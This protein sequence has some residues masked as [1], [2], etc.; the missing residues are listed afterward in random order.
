MLVLLTLIINLIPSLNNFLN[1]T[2]IFVQFPKIISLLGDVTPA[3][4][5]RIINIFSHPGTIILISALI[6]FWILNKS[7]FLKRSDFQGILKQTIE[8]SIPT[9]LVLFLMVGIAVIMSH[10]RMTDVLAQGLSLIFNKDLY[11]FISPFIGAVGAFITGSNAN[12]NVIFANLQMRTADLLGLSVPLILAAQ[13]AGGAIGSVLSPAKVFLGC[14]T[15]DVDGRE[16][17]V[18]G[19]LLVYGLILIIIIGVIISL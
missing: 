19:K 12:S 18:I 3:G 7:G 15:V 16:G 17:Q 8:G 5:G 10:T 2:K 4:P 14:S 1:Q 13:T 11:S 9:A 6:S